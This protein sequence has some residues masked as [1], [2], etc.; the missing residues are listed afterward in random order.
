MEAGEAAMG[1][2]VR[3]V[4]YFYATVRE[5]LGGSYRLLSDLAAEGVNLLAFN[6]IPLGPETT[7]LVLFPEDRDRL[8]RAARRTGLV[9]TGPESAFLVQGDDEL[10]ALADLHRQLH[11]R[12]LNPYA[13][14]GV[15]DGRG[16]Y[17]CVVYV[18]PEEFAAAAQALGL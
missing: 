11:D 5:R 17:G 15:S 4:E 6:A 13:S 12:G 3:A 8:L 9:V 7:Q 1:T 16:G 18:K 10:G 2:K 14:S